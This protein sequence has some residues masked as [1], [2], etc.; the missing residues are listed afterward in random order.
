MYIEDIATI[1]GYRHVYLSPHLDDAA[2]SCGG[3]IVTQIAAGEPVLV[4]TL[5]TAAPP[6]EGPFSALAQQFHADW[7]LAPAQAVAARLVEERLAMERLGCD[8]YWANML[9]AIYRYPAAYNSRESLFNTP[10]PDDPLFAQLRQFLADLLERLPQAQIYAP[11]GVGSHVD[12]LITHAAAHSLL[13][14]EL[15]FY[16]DLPYAIRPGA[17]EQRQAT[18]DDALVP[19][20][21]AIDAALPAK[22]EAIAA[23]ASQ[24][25]ELF[26]GSE[27]MAQAIAAYAHAATPTGGAYGE[28]LW[29]R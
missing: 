3:R 20:T 21:L 12:H 2:L 11:L 19:S 18:I 4:V 23:Y 10:A 29:V 22:I 26:G 14:D 17:L 25:D 27:A 24:L 8:Y 6:P 13:G 9:D 15:R 28:R 16:E 5:C 1:D 7:G